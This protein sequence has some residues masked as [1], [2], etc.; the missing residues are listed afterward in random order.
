MRAGWCTLRVARSRRPS[1]TPDT[2]ARFP[3]RKAT[4]SPLM[5]SFQEGCAAKRQREGDQ[6]DASCGAWIRIHSGSPAFLHLVQP[7]NR[8]LPIADPHVHVDT[9]RAPDFH[10]RSLGA[11]CCPVLAQLQRWESLLGRQLGQR[12]RVRG[13]ASV[14]AARHTNSPSAQTPRLLKSHLKS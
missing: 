12:G 14:G 11:A 8:I 13:G 7:G 2:E 3:H 4:F 9:S 5:R 10:A 6:H 1:D